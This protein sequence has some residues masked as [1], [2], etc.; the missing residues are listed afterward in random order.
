ME[1]S[2]QLH[3]PATLP[4]EKAPGT[5]CIGGW[6]GPRAGLDAVSNRKIP[7]PRQESNPNHP[8]VQP[9][10]RSTKTLYAF[11]ATLMRATSPAH[12]ILLHLTTLIIS[13]EY[14]K[15]WS[16]TLCNIIQF[17]F[18]LPFIVLSLMPCSLSVIFLMSDIKI[19]LTVGYLYLRGQCAAVMQREAVTVMQICSGRGNV[20][21]VWSSSL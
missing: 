5:H 7:S 17:S 8:I 14:Y 2:V 3:A 15:L 9:V 13:S 20:V 12:L 19:T 16:N 1:V 4:R 21:V 10:V 18:H 11:L 6:V